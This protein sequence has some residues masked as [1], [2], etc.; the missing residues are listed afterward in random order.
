MPRFRV[1][2]V[3]LALLVVL[4]V[5]SPT[6]SR[7]L[8]AT[9]AATPAAKPQPPP[10]PTT[11]PGSRETRFGGVTVIEQKPPDQFNADY[12]LF[13]PTDPLPGT[14]P[15]EE[16]LP[17]VIFVHG[18]TATSPDLYLSWVEHLVRRG[19]VVLYTE[20][21]GTTY[22]ETEY[23][24]NLLDDVRAALTTLERE[25]V[26]VDP[27]RVAVVGHSLGGVLAVDYAASAAAIGLPVPTAV[28]SVA[29]GCL[30]AE[31]ACLGADLG[32]IPATTRVLLVTEADDPDPVGAAAVERIWTGL[33][34]VPLDNRDVVTLVTDGHARPALL[35]VHTQALADDSYDKPDAF[36][37]YGTW[38]WLD[39]VMGCAFAG[40]W[41]EVALGNT[42][43][44]R[45]MGVWSDG[46]P[47]TEAVVTDDPATQALPEIDVAAQVL[48]AVRDADS[49]QAPATPVP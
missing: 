10:Q 33:G 36:D 18:Y 37:W 8:E 45:F 22:D 40:E 32:V 12:W 42:P 29:P 43:E 21:E 30:S 3:A 13:V 41:C 23:R 39:A 20:Y 6:S 49:R 48:E 44:Q 31:V 15:A 9:P 28:M 11:G 27:T 4:A 47:V 26:P 2:L 7:A 5:A 14:T 16:R 46:V 38:K 17:L 25:S 35:A 19:A 34:S 1:P 24:Q